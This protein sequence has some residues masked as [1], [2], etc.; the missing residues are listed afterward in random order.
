VTWT[1]R[2]R[3]RA[4]S[5]LLRYQ[6]I[7]PADLYVKLVTGAEKSLTRV[8]QSPGGRPDGDGMTSW[9]RTARYRA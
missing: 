6:D 3:E 9:A 1:A 4:R 2:P 8:L 5:F 7:L